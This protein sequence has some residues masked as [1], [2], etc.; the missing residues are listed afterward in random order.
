MLKYIYIYILEKIDYRLPTNLKPIE[1][2]VMLTPYIGTPERYGN[3][4]FTFDGQVSIL[5]KCVEPTNRIVLHE[6]DIVVHKIRLGAARQR[7]QEVPMS[8]V[9]H[10]AKREFLIINLDSPCVRNTQYTLSVEYM[11]H[12][13]DILAGFYRSSYLDENKTVN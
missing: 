10:D 1:Y 7:S 3:R 9:E 12:L 11:G 4:S 8:R 13:N 2:N 6:L 5:Y